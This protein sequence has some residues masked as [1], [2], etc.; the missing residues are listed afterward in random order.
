MLAPDRMPGATFAL[1]DIGFIDFETRS[2]VDL[3]AAGAYRYA[4]EGHAVVLAYAI[5]DRP[6]AV[7]SAAGDPL[8]WEDIPAEVRAHH[9]RVAAGTAT[10]AAWN[11]AFDKAIWNYGTDDFPV[12]EPWHV[13]DVM[14]QAAAAGL[15]PDLSAAARFVNG[16]RKG[17]KGRELIR[18]FSMSTS[19]GTPQSHPAEW[20]EF[21][22]YA[23]QDIAAMRA[24]FLNTRQL[25]RAEWREYWAMEAI[26]ERGVA[27]DVA[28]VSH[29]AKLAEEDK[30]R[31]RSELVKLTNGEVTTVDQVKRM[32]GWLQARLPAEGREMLVKRAEEVDEDGVVTK[33]AKHELTRRKVERLIAFCSRAPIPPELTPVLRLLQIR[34]YGGSKT[35]QKFAKMLSSHVDG[36]LFGQYVFNGA[37]QTGRAS[38]RGVQVHNLARD[39]LENEHGTI[40]ALLSLCSYADLAALSDTP[41]ARI[42]SLLIRPAFVA[43]EGRTFVWSDWSQIEARVLPW[44]CD[45]FPGARVRLQIFRDVDADPKNVP[46]LYTRTAATLS[47]VPI[48][49]VTKPMRQRGKVAELAL[50]FCG[51]VGALQNM[52]AAYGLH[53]SDEDA[54]R[55]VDDWRAANPWSKDFSRELWDAML[56][57]HGLPGHHFLAGRVAFTFLPDYLGGSLMVTLPSHRVLT[58]RR[59]RWEDLDVLDDDGNPTGEKKR[60][61]TFARGHGRVKLWPGLF[62]ENVTQAVAADVLRGTLVRLEESG[63]FDVRLHTHDEILVECPEEAAD[64]VSAQLRAIMQQGFDWSNGLPIMSEETVSPYYTKAKE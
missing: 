50:G 44:L 48:E 6:V 24:V 49:A 12:M 60:E 19:T 56:R 62:V 30:S 45:H 28:M 51:G 17:E 61:M 15:P 25:P 21:L 4:T 14:A 9:A 11:A 18:L 3:K 20:Q 35:P 27:I 55:T 23:G 58:Y 40:E 7:V 41:V 64:T 57:A 29:A 5:G 54:R 8:S 10:W 38:S 59:L 42:L 53:L 32:V 37:G 13:I 52:A 34:L 63:A 43:P 22:R 26:N 47:R 16:E 31:S 39:T 2:L 36:V 1:D 46:D 33:V